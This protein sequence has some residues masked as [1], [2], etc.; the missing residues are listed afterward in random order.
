MVGGCPGRASRVQIAPVGG[1][2]ERGWM[3]WVVSAPGE[4]GAAVMRS[5]SGRCSGH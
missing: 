1:S 4:G 3:G 2:G 5:E